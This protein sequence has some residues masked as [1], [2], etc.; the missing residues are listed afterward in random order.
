[1]GDG[2]GGRS[3]HQV[4]ETH[5]RRQLSRR[6]A[7]ACARAGGNYLALELGSASYRGADTRALGSFRL[8]HAWLNAPPTRPARSHQAWRRDISSHQALRIWRFYSEFSNETHNYLIPD[9][10]EEDGLVEAPRVSTTNIGM[11]LNAR[12]AAADLW[13]YYC[14][15]VCGHDE[16]HPLASIHKLEKLNG[17]PYNWYDTQTLMPL[18][19]VTISSVDNGNLAASLYTLRAGS[20]ALLKMPLLRP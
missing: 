5:T 12:Q 14:S 13:L 1:M 20:L 3:K 15:R 7:C 2:C 19:P 4:E 6:H 10:V 9:N 8:N 11:L 17:H 16:A 18:Q